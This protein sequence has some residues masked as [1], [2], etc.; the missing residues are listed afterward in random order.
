MSCTNSFGCNFPDSS[1]LTETIQKIQEMVRPVA[2]TAQRIREIIRPITE[3]VS[4]YQLEIN[5]TIHELSVAFRPLKAIAKM[6]EAQFVSWDY[7]SKDFMEAI[8]ATNNTNKTLREYLAREK[9]KSVC[10]TIEKCENEPL[11]KKH[12]RLFKQSVSAYNR[13][14]SDLAVNGFTSVFDG[15]LSDITGN[16]THKL[17]PRIQTIRDKLEKDEILDN[18]E[19]AML[20]LA[21]TFEKTIESFSKPAPFETEEPKGLNRHWIAHG[22]S[23]RKKT[24]LDCVKLINLIYGLLLINKL[25]KTGIANVNT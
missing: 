2:E 9:F 3:F 25:D 11:M 15:L 12:F 24:V 19:Y 14:D 8:F 6:G 10:N 22:R 5:K 16:S 7:L 4:E 13:G 1:P 18:D 20:T 21:L 17:Q 23:S